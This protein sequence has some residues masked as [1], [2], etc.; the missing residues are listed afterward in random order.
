MCG[1]RIS[2]TMVTCTDGNY[3]WRELEREVIA[4]GASLH[5]INEDRRSPLCILIEKYTHEY[6]LGAEQAGFPLNG[7]KNLLYGW[8]ADLLSDEKE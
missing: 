1:S 2:K 8:L 6:Y 3:M 5:A 4:A 7:L